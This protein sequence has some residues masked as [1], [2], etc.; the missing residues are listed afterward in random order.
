MKKLIAVLAIVCLISGV[1]FAQVSGAVIG[2]FDALTG[3]TAKDAAD[4]TAD[5]GAGGSMNRIRIEA[6]GTTEEGNFGAWFRYEGQGFGYAWWKPMDMLLLRIGNNGY[7]GFNG[8]D[9]VT[10]WGFYQT[11]SD[12]GVSF[13]GDNAWGDTIYDISLGGSTYAALNFTSAFFGGY[14][15][16]NAFM[17]EFSPM[18]MLGINISLPF[19]NGKLEDLYKQLTA[20]VN[21]NLAFGNIAITYA[22]GAAD[23]VEDWQ[24]NIAFNSGTIYAYFGIPINDN[25]SLDVGLGY[26][27][28]Y[29]V[30][31]IIYTRPISAGIGLKYAT[32]SFGVK[33]RA[34]GSFAGSA[35]QDVSGATAVDIPM[36]ILVDV[37]PYFNL[38]ESMTVFISAGIGFF[39]EYKAG[40]IK[41][42]DS[43]FGWHINPMLQV[44]SEWGPKFLAGVKIWSPGTKDDKKNDYINFAIPLAISVGF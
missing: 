35:K 28:E 17:I 38:S 13:G 32:D 37:L 18:E 40:S 24:G 41:I 4:K 30:E 11:I 21:L 44:G 16:S 31:N 34:M 43:V 7:D 26:G 29:K 2:T 19:A 1:A 10:R 6:S 8:K 22:G 23:A 25:F 20:Q 33:L 3:S 36:G 12:T 9:G 15:G 27:M 5:L 14:G 42:A 39:D